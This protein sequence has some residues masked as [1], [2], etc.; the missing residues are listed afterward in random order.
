MSA[1]ITTI[2]KGIEGV[3][4]ELFLPL[5]L[6]YKGKETQQLKNAEG[7]IENAKQSQKTKNKIKSL[8]DTDLDSLI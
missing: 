8:D 2:I 1:W 7:A 4:K 6:Y 5:F 3:L